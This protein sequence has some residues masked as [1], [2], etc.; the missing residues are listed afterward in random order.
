MWIP[1]G[2]VFLGLVIFIAQL[3]AYLIHVVRGGEPLA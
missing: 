2:L 1:E 3:I